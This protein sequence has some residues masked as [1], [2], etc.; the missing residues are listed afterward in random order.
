[1]MD[2]PKI[3][4]GF[5][6][7]NI[8]MVD[9]VVGDLT[10]NLSGI[11]ATSSTGLLQCM[12]GQA[13]SAIE[14]IVGEIESRVGCAA[15]TATPEAPVAF[16]LGAFAPGTPET[17]APTEAPTAPTTI[18]PTEGVHIDADPETGEVCATPDPTSL[19]KLEV[20][21]IPADD[22]VPGGRNVLGISIKFP[23]ATWHNEPLTTR[24]EDGGQ[25][26]QLRA[27][28]AGLTNA[29]YGGKLRHAAAMELLTA[30]GPVTGEVAV[31]SSVDSLNDLTKAEA[32][33][34]LDWLSKTPQKPEALTQL[35]K[36]VKIMGGNK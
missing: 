18:T 24:D 12:T 15:P 9:G 23:P 33:I 21:T 20:E 28:N 6:A 2:E 36:A 11:P 16:N 25:G 27:L 34:L 31:R 13:R 14:H 4:V 7:K 3:H 30:Y 10:I 26:G 22:D 17:A 35:A 8:R 19:Q 1:M 32:S 5:T 29:G